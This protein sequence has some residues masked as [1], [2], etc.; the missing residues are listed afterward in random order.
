MHARTLGPVESGRPTNMPSG[1]C[2]WCLGGRVELERR[3]TALQGNGFIVLRPPN[4]LHG[5][6]GDAAYIS[7]FLAQ[8]TAGPVVL[9]GHS[10]GGV[11]ITNAAAGASQR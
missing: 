8:R 7:S 10:Y 9:G 5:V 11:V 1:A 4:L 3:S 2:P 6:A